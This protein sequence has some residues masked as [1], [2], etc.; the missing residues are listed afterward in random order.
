MPDDTSTTL[1]DPRVRRLVEEARAEGW[2]AGIEAAAALHEAWAAAVRAF[3]I[4]QQAATLT[5]PDLALAYQQHADDTR[6]LTME[7]PHDR[8]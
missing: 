7:E 1:S 6:A 8:H 5:I 3:P 2:R 4:S